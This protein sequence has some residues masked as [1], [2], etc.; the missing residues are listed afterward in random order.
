MT[1][2]AAAVPS[3][4]RSRIKRVEATFRDNLRRVTVSRMEGKEDRSKGLRTYMDISRMTMEMVMLNERS[5]SRRNVGSGM[6]MII[7]TPITPIPRM[8]VPLLSH[9]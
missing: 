9:L 4:P 2:P 6:I 8:A 5:K 1:W 3:L 7:S